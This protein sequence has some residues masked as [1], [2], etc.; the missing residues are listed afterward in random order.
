MIEGTWLENNFVLG[1]NYQLDDGAQ[2]YPLPFV[3]PS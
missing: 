3:D 1:L 2:K